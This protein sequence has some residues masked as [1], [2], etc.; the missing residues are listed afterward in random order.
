MSEA[1]FSFRSHRHLT[2]TFNVWPLKILKNVYQK[3][4]RAKFTQQKCWPQYKKY[5]PAYIAD[6]K[7]LG[8][9]QLLKTNCNAKLHQDNAS[10]HAPPLP[11]LFRPSVLTSSEE[12]QNLL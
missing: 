11:D 10:A 9:L 12:V 4:R 6:K 8:R 1:K 7:F 2:F 3:T 5:I